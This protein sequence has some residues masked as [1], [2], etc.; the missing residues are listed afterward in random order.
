VARPLAQRRDS[1]ST[2]RARKGRRRGKSAKGRPCTSPRIELWEIESGDGDG[3][4]GMGPEMEPPRPRSTGPRR[5][6]GA[7]AVR[8]GTPA[9]PARRGRAPTA[10]GARRRRCPWRGKGAHL[11]YLAPASPSAH[12]RSWMGALPQGPDLDLEE[13]RGR[14]DGGRRLGPAG[15]WDG[16]SP[17]TP[18]E[19]STDPSLLHFAAPVAAPAGAATVHF[20]SAFCRCS[21]LCSICRRQSNF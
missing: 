21:C 8:G 18:R 19:C 15:G 6:S 9:S 12:R 13:G 5:I 14:R 2:G 3:A 17:Q 7:T 20:R 4:G 11:P 10:A 16:G 1:G